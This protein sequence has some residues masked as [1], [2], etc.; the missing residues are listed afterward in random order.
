MRSCLVA[1]AAA[2]VGADGKLEHPNAH[3]PST[4]VAVTSGSKA[5]TPTRLCNRLCWN[6]VKSALMPGLQ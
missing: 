1:V 6:T 2:A 4:K 3:A 5:A